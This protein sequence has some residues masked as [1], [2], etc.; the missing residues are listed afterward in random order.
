MHDC[1]QEQGSAACPSVSPV[2]LPL[3]ASPPQQHLQTFECRPGTRRWGGTKG[4][5]AGQVV[6]LRH[7]LSEGVGWGGRQAREHTRL[8]NW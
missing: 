2:P 1:G 6:D 7:W 4:S 5:T 3:P 8:H